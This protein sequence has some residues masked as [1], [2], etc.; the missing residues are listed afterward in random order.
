MTEFYRYRGCGR[1]FFLPHP[2]T[3][4]RQ[5]AIALLAAG[6]K[7]KVLA[8]FFNRQDADDQARVMNRLFM[9]F[10]KHKNVQPCRVVVFFDPPELVDERTI[11]D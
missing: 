6:E 4:S 1:R 8:R 7:V 11:D 2:H 10:T 5:W 3:P 9:L